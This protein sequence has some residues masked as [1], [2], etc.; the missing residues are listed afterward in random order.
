MAAT[1]FAARYNFPPTE[2][3]A[4]DGPGQTIAI[5]E[6][7]GGFRTS[8]LQVF[9]GEIGSPVPRVTAVSVDDAGNHPTTA[10]SDDGEVM[11]DIEVAGA[12]APN[13]MFASTSRPNSGDKGF[14]DA[15]SAAVHDS[16]RNP[17]V[18]SISWGG[19]EDLPPQQ[20]IDAVPRAVRRGGLTGHHGMRGVG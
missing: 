19:P 4:V 17:R 2:R 16:E 7:G 15:I 14:M 10:D 9:F 3:H 1:E 20:G 11:L 5:I 12:V 13:A 8:D 6:L 18:I